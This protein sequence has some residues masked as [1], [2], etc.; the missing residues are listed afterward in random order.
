MDLSWV[1]FPTG[2][3]FLINN[4]NM[5]KLIKFN[6]EARESLKKG[7]DTLANAVKVTLG[8]KGR[9]V[10]YQKQ[11][12]PK[13]TKD[14]VTVAQ[15]VFL[16]D[17]FE[18]VGAQLVKE[19]SAR[20]NDDA[21][22]GPQP[23]YSKIATPTGWVK[24]GDI[25]IGDEIC[26][27]NNSIQKVVGIYPKGKK[28][29]YKV[30][31][32]NG[33]EVHCCKD[34]LWTITMPWGKE[35]LLTTQNMLE[36]GIYK[37]NSKNVKRFN[38]FIPN[39]ITNYNY[40]EPKIDPFLMGILI[41][42]GYIPSKDKNSGIV[43][44][45]IGYNKI[46][47]IIPNIIL[48]EGIYLS[49]KDYP[50]KHA[51][52][53]CILGKDKDGNKF[54]DYLNELNYID[55]HSS[56]KFIPNIYLYNSV[57]VRNKILNGLLV[58]DGYINK[59][60]LF[61]YSTTSEKLANDIMNLCRSIGKTITAYKHDHAKDD[62]AYGNKIVYRVVELK[63]NKYGN[64][65][66]NI[67][68]T[69]QYEEMQCIKVSNEDE[70]YITN[71]YILTHNT[72]TATVLAQAIVQYGMMYLSAGYNPIEIKNGIDYAVSQVVK[73]IKNSAEKVDIDKIEQVATISAN[74]DS[75]IGAL[76]KS[77]FEQV[78]LNGVITL[79][80]GNAC[81]TYINTVTGTRI[82]RGY[83]S[84][85][86]VT[87]M[88][89][90]ECVLEKPNI[91]I[92]DKKITSLKPLLAILESCAQRHDPLL[93]ICDNMDSEVLNTLVLNK[94][95]G[96]LK[97]CV[98]KA[99][100]FGEKREEA[101]LN[102]CKLTGTELVRDLDNIKTL[103]HAGKVVVTQDTTT[104]IDGDCEDKQ[105]GV[106]VIYVGANSELEMNEKKDRIE[107]ALCATRAAI[108]EGVV[109]GGSV[110]YLRALG[111][112]QSDRDDKDFKAG[113]EIVREALKEPLKCIANNAG[114]IGEVIVEKV[115]SMS[116]HEGYDAKNDRFC[117]LQEAGIMDPAKVERTALENAA[118]VASMF[119]TTECAIV[120]EHV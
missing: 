55:K 14:G 25:Q 82:D 28:E 110:T 22:D 103:G 33:Q 24:M 12:K 64:K 71:D 88:E 53:Y 59:N 75:E 34:H 107:D 52:R 104:I 106:A 29:L 87:N 66:I 113:V 51:K 68:P 98:I 100:E 2:D 20:T 44:F 15:N 91:L 70:L 7:L 18:N 39:V 115:M 97:V 4:V 23:L 36:N 73:Y 79:E 95:Q 81:E 69:G 38:Y 17:E 84:P 37:I 13:I 26:G 43:E 11:G 102:I 49:E 117:N 101:L 80:E 42:D 57:E 40:Q 6:D 112:L 45:T 78:G 93:I 120:D 31:F 61:E 74:N 62:S 48:P 67:I 77:A 118:S 86:L 46:N 72:T 114:K 19:V 27:T 63:G 90:Q 30:I 35:K 8:P 10:V 96:M 50:K 94:I 21:G 85:N 5:D 32:E 111:A 1:R 58:T 16:K 56:D 65:I 41:G 54:I 105:G 99:P 60:N 119:L 109:T 9:N 92:T 108:A 3:L 89:T 116:G 76:I 83:L 47:K